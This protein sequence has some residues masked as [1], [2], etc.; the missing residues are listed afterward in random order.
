MRLLVTGTDTGIGKTTISVLLLQAAARHKLSAAAMKP[1]ASGAELRDGALRNTDALA[2]QS[3]ST[4]QATYEDVNPY[5]YAAAIAPHI[6]QQLQAATP[7]SAARLQ[8]CAARL[9]RACDLF[10]VEGAGGFLSPLGVGDQSGSAYI[11]HAD[12]VPL[13]ALDGVLLV[14]GLRLGCI[15][16]AR[17]SE[18]A[19]MRTG[20]RPL[21]A[22]VSVLDPHM[23]AL[24]ENIDSLRS[25]LQTPIIAIVHAHA[26]NVAREMDAA[27]A[28]ILAARA[29]S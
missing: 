3:A 28:L 17:L 20:I 9:S 4:V 15:N 21:A 22:I 11:E 18:V 8:S 7:I 19:I 26:L 13:L 1:I 12:L 5:C 25:L 6:A 10:L 27:L 14:I 23:P 16:H 29:K 2:L 24:A